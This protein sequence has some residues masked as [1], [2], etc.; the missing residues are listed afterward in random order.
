MPTIVVDIK[1]L[2][3]KEKRVN[4][5]GIYYIKKYLDTWKRDQKVIAVCYHEGA[6]NRVF[7]TFCYA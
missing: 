6:F 5:E 4:A 7:D 1:L 3:S 2:L